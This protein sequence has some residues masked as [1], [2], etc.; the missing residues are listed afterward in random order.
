ML[1]VNDEFKSWMRKKL[2][3]RDYAERVMKVLV[4]NSDCTLLK[5][6][7]HAALPVKMVDDPEVMIGL[8]KG[9]DNVKDKEFL[10]AVFGRWEDFQSVSNAYIGMLWGM[11]KP[12]TNEDFE[13][14]P[15][16]YMVAFTKN[17]SDQP[18]IKLR[19]RFQMEVNGVVTEE[20]EYEEVKVNL[21]NTNVDSNL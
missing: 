2:S 6:H 8:I 20:R 14:L 19:N 7:P 4:D 18:L 10:L 15:Q 5:V 16:I 1:V 9:Y 21:V 11:Y 13:N 17:E 12:L 3:D